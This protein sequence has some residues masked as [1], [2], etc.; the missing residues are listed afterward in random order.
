VHIEDGIERLPDAM[1]GLF[2]KSTTGKVVIRVAPMEHEQD[3]ALR[4]LVKEKQ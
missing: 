4:A 1:C 3:A 2:E